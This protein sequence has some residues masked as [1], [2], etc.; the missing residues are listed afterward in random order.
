MRVFRAKPDAFAVPITLK[1]W[2]VI[3]TSQHIEENES[4][5]F[6]TWAEAMSLATVDRLL[7]KRR[8]QWVRMT[9]ALLARML[10]LSDDGWKAPAIA[11][12]LGVSVGSIYGHL[13]RQKVAA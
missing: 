7:P 13:A 9:D 4:Q 11:R 12:E 10:E 3:K 1:P 2:C 8:R 6:A 5:W